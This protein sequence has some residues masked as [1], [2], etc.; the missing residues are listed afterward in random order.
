[1]SDYHVLVSCPL[2][3][4]SMEAYNDH[5]ESHGI[6]YDIAEVDQYLREG[7][8]IDI[9]PEYDGILAGD[10]ELTQHVIEKSPRLKVISKWGVGT[11]S[12]NLDAADE[13]NVYVYNTPGAFNKEVADVVIGYTIMLARHLHQIDKAVRAGRWACPRGTSLAGKTFGVIGVGDIGSTVARQAHNLGMSV[14]GND[15]RPIQTDLKQEIGID[16]VDKTELLKN[17]TVVSLNCALTDATKN[18]IGDSELELIGP[19]GFLINTARGELVDEKA[20]INAL[21]NGSIKGAALDVYHEE[22]LPP[23]SPLTEIDNVILG[24]HNAQ[25]TQEAV[26]RVNERAIENLIKGLTNG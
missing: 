9:L 21:Q 11:D 17:S 6:E 20:L 18:L 7:E 14:L 19:D 15:V 13:N 25:N 3:L 2:I 24:T 23:E 12:I 16:F 26:D 22:P 5:L 4:D 8:L 1:M 10:D